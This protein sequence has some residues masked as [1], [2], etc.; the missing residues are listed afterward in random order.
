MKKFVKN[1]EI[2]IFNKLVELLGYQKINVKKVPFEELSLVSYKEERNDDDLSLLRHEYLPM[3]T[4]PFILVVISIIFAIGL[5]TTFLL[6]NIL[7]KDIDKLLYFFILMLPAFIF[8]LLAT[9][10]SF[11]R[12]FATLK[13]IERYAYIPHLEKKISKHE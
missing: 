5:A 3:S 6:I 1:S 8:M 7:N 9:F 12:Y 13:N 10:I 4:P 11:R 2:D